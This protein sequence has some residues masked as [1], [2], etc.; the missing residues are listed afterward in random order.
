[1]KR[2]ISIILIAVMLLALSAITV[3]S[4]NV[5]QGD[6]I[7]EERFLDEYPP[8]YG[9][10]EYQEFYY[11]HIDE[12]DPNSEIDWILVEAMVAMEDT[13]YCTKIGNRIL[14]LYSQE[15]PFSCGYGVYDV[16]QDC[17]I[18]LASRDIFE[19]YE[20][21]ED[22]VNNKVRIGRLLGDTDLDDCLSI[23]DA[24]TLQR[25]LVNGKYS[26]KYGMA[27]EV[28]DFDLDYNVTVMDATAIQMHLAGIKSE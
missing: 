5:Y 14:F 17:F 8:D 2:I 18:S 16:K 7:Y 4:A 24:T 19:K 13:L 20:D 1:M 23:L 6:Y 25:G 15:Y 28:A 21:L 22:V 3:F 26:E 9:T 11:H 10:Y 12:N 27:Y